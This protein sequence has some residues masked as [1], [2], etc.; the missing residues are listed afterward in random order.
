MPNLTRFVIALPA[1]G[2]AKKDAKKAENETKKFFQREDVKVSLASW[3][4][5]GACGLKRQWVSYSL[6]N[7]SP[8]GAARGRVFRLRLLGWNPFARHGVPC[9][10]IALAWCRPAHADADAGQMLRFGPAIEA[11]RLAGCW[12]LHPFL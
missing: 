6:S 1:P 9:T 10:A 3:I 2:D 4:S 8:R 7:S 12:S 5:D 11:G